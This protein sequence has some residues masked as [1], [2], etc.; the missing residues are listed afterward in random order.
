MEKDCP[1]RLAALTK[2]ENEKE[3][4]EEKEEKDEQEEKCQKQPEDGA[5]S[6]PRN[7]VLYLL[8]YS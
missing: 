5:R 2:E 8:H 7:A 3:K 6:C 1:Q 4:E